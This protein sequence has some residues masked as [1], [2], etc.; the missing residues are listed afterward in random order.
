MITYEYYE[1]RGLDPQG[2]MPSGMFRVAETEKELWYEIVTMEGQWIMDNECVRY[3]SGHADNAMKTSKKKADSFV[4][5]LKS[6]EAA[7]DKSKGK[8]R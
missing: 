3:F 4:E 1:L 2:E 5:Y 6:G 8:W 7:T